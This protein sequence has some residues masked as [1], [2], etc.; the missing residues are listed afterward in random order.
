MLGLP[1]STE[2]HKV[3]PKKKVYEHFGSEMSADRR[4]R[5]DTDIAR[6][7]LTNEVSPIS[8]NIVAG[9]NVQN[10]FVLQVTLRTKAFDPQNIALLAHLFGQR[11]L[12]VLESNSEERL[13]L[14]QTKLLMTEWA[15]QGNWSIELS[16]L[17]LDKV[18]ERIVTCVAGI[19]IQQGRTLDEEIAAAARRERLQRDMQ[20]LEKAART[21][22]QPRRKFELVQQIK[23]LQAEWEEI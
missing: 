5:F 3:I 23:A 21:E 6:M 18:W 7:V 1:K 22:K 19:E 20:R 10:F 8:L 15:T 11:L 16:G 13:A 17:N 4:K 12:M 2:I 14:W 9:E